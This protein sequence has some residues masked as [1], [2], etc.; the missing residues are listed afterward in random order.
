MPAGALACTND[1]SLAVATGMSAGIA[2]VPVT[3]RTHCPDTASHT[4][5]VLSSDPDTM[6]A[7]SGENDTDFTASVCPS[8]GPSTHSPDTASHTRKDEIMLASTSREM[9]DN[10]LEENAP[11]TKVKY[12]EEKN[13]EQNPDQIAVPTDKNQPFYP[14]PHKLACTGGNASDNQCLSGHDTVVPLCATCK[15][16]Y[17][18]SG[19]KPMQRCEETAAPG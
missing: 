12:G 5:T 9:E 10:V 13:G 1:K 15:D 14:C 3:T 16:G 6:R 7:P 11:L 17:F 8:S 19:V 4:R 2:D 18:L